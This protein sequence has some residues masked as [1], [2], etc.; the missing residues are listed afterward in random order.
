M[1]RCIVTA[2]M[3]ATAAR[4]AE[5]CWCVDLRSHPCFGMLVALMAARNNG[6]ESHTARELGAQRATTAKGLRL[7]LGARTNRYARP[8]KARGSQE[9]RCLLTLKHEK[10][11][12]RGRFFKLRSNRTIVTHK[13]G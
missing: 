13:G 9:P 5:M 12:L 8:L 6:P 2:V 11:T 3:A 7:Y 4:P 10:A 1:G